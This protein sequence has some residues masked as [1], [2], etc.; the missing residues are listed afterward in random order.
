[1]Y[2][3]GGD[4]YRNRIKLDFSVNV[5]PYG[6]PPVVRA[7]LMKSF[8]QIG[9]YPDM[10]YES[11]RLAISK[12][13]QVNANHILCGNGASEL[14]YASFRGLRNVLNLE[15][16]EVSLNGDDFKIGLIEPCFSEYKKASLAAGFIDFKE[17]VLGEENDFAVTLD[18][19]EQLANESKVIILGNPNNPTGKL[20]PKKYIEKLVKK[21]EA[22]KKFLIIDESFLPLTEVLD[23][24]SDI[25][26]DYL[27]RIK[28]FTKSMAVPGVR[29]GY[30]ICENEVLLE[31]IKEQLPEWNVSIPAVYV[32]EAACLSMDFLHEKITDNKTGLR[33]ERE[34]LE[35][36]LK[37][38]GI[39]VYKSDT[40]FLLVKSKYPLYDLL[41]KKGI[42]IRACQNFNGLDDKFF[43]IAIRNHDENVILIN[44][45]NE[46]IKKEID[47]THENE[48]HES[49]IE[50]NYNS[51][52]L[53]HVMPKDIENTSFKI[54]TSELN[55][56]GIYLDGDSAPIIKRCIHTTADFEYVNTL[57]FSEKAVNI[58]KEL[59]RSGAD[60]VTDTNMAL[61]GINKKELEKYGGQVHCFMADPEIARIAKEKGKTRAS[62]SMEHAAS[63]DKKLIFVV[64]NAP[65]ALVTLCEMMDEG[66]YTPDFVIGVPVGFVNVEQAKEMI[67]ERNVPYIVNR[68]RKGGSNVAAAIVNAILYDMRED[69]NG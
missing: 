51:E 26:S 8:L 57:C 20:I 47:G 35:N 55:A 37:N 61:S 40:S 6:M 44:A 67:I 33:K 22:E 36:E 62:M 52:A 41:L 3:H 16:V 69:N 10:V 24:Y 64:G 54:L 5:S 39:T 28:S 53:I 65:T 1:M 4:I 27:I 50:C 32:S 12:M 29:A 15:K 2:E 38:I 48:S 25:H 19:L 18:Y 68:G 13:E 11:L 63:L 42:L 46:E 14:I 59:I 17:L 9:C 34:F 66:K 31:K 60:I 30:L 7:A 58:I 56:K 21:I 45:I 49:S 43:R 23:E